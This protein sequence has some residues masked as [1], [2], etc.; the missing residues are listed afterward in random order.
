M[1][2]SIAEADG[3]SPDFNVDTLTIARRNFL[4]AA[5]LGGALLTTGCG[6]GTLPA[7]R[8]T[9]VSG[10]VEGTTLAATKSGY[11]PV[12]GLRMYYEVY[13]A[14][15]PV[16]L[17]H[18]AFTGIEGSFAQLIPVLARSHQVVALESQGHGRTADIPDR[19]LT[20]EQMSDDVAAAIAHLGLQTPD[21][22]GYSMGALTGLQLAIRHPASIR[23]MTL[24]AATFRTSGWHPEL[25]TAE[26][27]MTGKAM[28][29]TPYYK[30]Y[31]RLAPDASR[32]DAL[33]DKIRVLDTQTPQDWP[34]ASIRAIR[35]PT[36][37]IYGDSDA[38][39]L[40]HAVE[41][42]R[43]LGGGVAGDLVPMPASRLAVLAG[44]NHEGLIGRGPEIGAMVNAFLDAV[45]PAAKGSA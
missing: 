9:A 8:K 26:R 37:L 40:E 33:T 27:T 35:A 7:R 29:E 23:K 25:M 31:A 1:T 39:R 13:G 42:F 38:V 44:C 12:N 16:V 10:S 17:L 5:M 2:D 45:P 20:Y 28:R 11:A 24:A 36:L 21:I 18:G 41:L 19:P 30:D 15:R 22:Y 43:L 34:E 4:S 32:W 14:G 6:S 3:Q